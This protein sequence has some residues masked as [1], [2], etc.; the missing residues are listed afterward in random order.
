V[1]IAFRALGARVVVAVVAGLAIAGCGDSSEESTS[2]QQS[3][4]S[5]N[6]SAGLA[7]AKD[8]VAQYTAEQPPLA[9]DPL[10][11][12]SEAGL[13]FNFVGCTIPV[14]HQEGFADA[15]KALGWNLSYEAFQLAPEQFVSA[16]GR[17]L[18]QPPEVMGFAGPFPQALVK[19]ELATVEQM[20][21]PLVTVSTA[22]EEPINGAVKACF[23]CAPHFELSGKLMADFVAADAGGA[24]EIVYVEDPSIPALAPVW[25]GFSKEL[26][27]VSPSSK[28]DKLQVSA[29][30]QA[31]KTASTVVSYVQSH[32]NVKYV[33]FSG[34]QYTPGV[35]EALA[36]AGLSDKVKVI[37]RAPQA[38]NMSYI[39]SGGQYASV[40]EES[41]E[42]TWRAVDALA[43]LNQGVELKDP[44]PAGWH[45]IITK[46]NVDSVT[47]DIPVAPG[48]PDA[49]LKAWHVEQ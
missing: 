31:T 15:A 6:D 35:P 47:G 34:D 16:W 24:T 3:A 25:E 30:Q 43:R 10:P 23:V 33:V 39:R 20:K 44:M 2:S 36:S 12:P 19:N 32:P 37:G 28:V 22:D 29:L 8:A 17:A 14:C 46:D 13:T 7:A 1:S 48:F 27:A 21:I 45:Q 40:A 5:S 9:I 26:K 41:V 38:Q 11:K 49:F 18:Q 4:A 42:S